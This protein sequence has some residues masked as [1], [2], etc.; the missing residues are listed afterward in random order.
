MENSNKRERTI[1]TCNLNELQRH[2]TERNKPD[3]RVHTVP[4]RVY[5][6]PLWMQEECNYKGIA[7]K[8]WG[9]NGTVMYSY[10]C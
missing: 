9:R 1:D 3:T 4:F 8:V 2:D 7:W 6:V 10:M 5:G